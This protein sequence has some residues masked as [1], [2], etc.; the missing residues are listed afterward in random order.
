IAVEKD[1]NLATLLREE[2]K[3]YSTDERLTIIEGDILDMQTVLSAGPQHNH[4]GETRNGAY[5]VVANIPYY[6]TGKILR[7]LF[8]LDTLPTSIVLLIQDEVARRIT[9]QEGRKESILSLSIKAYGTPS[10]K[11]KIKAGAFSPAPKVDSA[12]L[13]IEHISRD[14]FD[15]FSETQFFN[16]IKKAFSQ[17][18]KTLLNTLFHDNKE[19]GAKILSALRLSPAVRP[20]ELTLGIWKKLIIEMNNLEVSE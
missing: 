18:R 15:A 17:K 4:R 16:V 14:Y 11:G 10:Y 1:E 5:K 8:S 13:S 7:F 9:V 3:K 2:L 6:I 12:I 20:E 19:R